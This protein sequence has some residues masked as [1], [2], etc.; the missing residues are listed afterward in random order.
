MNDPNWKPIP[1]YVGFYEANTSGE[2]RGIDRIVFSRDGKWHKIETKRIKIRYSGRG[3]GHVILG[4]GLGDRISYSASRLIALTF[5]P[6]PDNK[7]QVNHINGIKTD[8]RVENLEWVTNQENCFHR[9]RVLGKSTLDSHG[10]AK[11]KS[12]QIY[13][14]RLFRS[15]GLA[16]HKI[17]EIF[18]VKAPAIM[19]IIKGTIWRGIGEFQDSNLIDHMRKPNRLSK[20][21]YPA[22]TNA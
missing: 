4:R 12:E 11:L 5:I 6:N 9:T 16:Y 10:K 19:Q 2:I 8:N 22:T 3:W 17:G 1:G 18:G 15:H 21:I 20:N 7:P 13:L 14:I